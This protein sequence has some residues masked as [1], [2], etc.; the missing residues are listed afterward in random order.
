MGSSGV[1]LANAKGTS[2]HAANPVE[3]VDVTGAGDAFWAGLVLATLDGYPLP[4]A[5]R[6]AQAVTEIKLQQVG[7]LSHKLDRTELYSKL[8]LGGISA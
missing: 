2:Y 6:V 8:G 5:I 1:L 7:P 3:V 4:E